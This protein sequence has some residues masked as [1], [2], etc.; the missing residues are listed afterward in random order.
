MLHS[1]LKICCYWSCHWLLDSEIIIF[2]LKESNPC[3]VVQGQEKQLNNKAEIYN[4]NITDIHILL[5]QV[6]WTTLQSLHNDTS[7]TKGF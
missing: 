7:L 6:Q 5:K 1:I 3:S 2:P 4:I